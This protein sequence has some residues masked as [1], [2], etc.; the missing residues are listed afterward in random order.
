MFVWPPVAA[1]SPTLKLIN[2]CW[3]HWRCEIRYCCKQCHTIVTCTV[4]FRTLKNT[5]QLILWE[6]INF[7]GLVLKSNNVLSGGRKQTAQGER[8]SFIYRV[9]V[10]SE[11]M[12]PAV[13]WGVVFLRKCISILP[14]ITLSEK[15]AAGASRFV[16]TERGPC[17]LS[18]QPIRTL[19]TSTLG[20]S[21][22]KGSSKWCRVL[23]EGYWQ[24][25]LSWP[26]AGVHTP[27]FLGWARTNQN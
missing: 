26:S 6:V 19:T 22:I 12:K 20:L 10:R 27:L 15:R 5:L 1:N 11:R 14:G 21:L 4:L 17:L 2:L 8:D 24:R 3:W 9:E 25:L 7:S 18:I 23:A 16:S 13:A